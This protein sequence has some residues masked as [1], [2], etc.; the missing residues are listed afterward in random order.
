MNFDTRK[1]YPQGNGVRY[2]YH[3][4]KSKFSFSLDSFKGQ[5]KEKLKKRILGIGTAV[6]LIFAFWLTKNVVS[7]L[8]DVSSINNMVFSEATVIQDRNGK[9][10]YRLFEQNREYV[11]FSGISQNMINGIVAIEDQRYWDHNGLDPMGILRAAASNVFSPGKGLQ[12]AS[13]ISQQLVRNL[14]LSKGQTFMEKVTRKLKEMILTSRLDSVLEDQIQ[15]ENGELDSDMLRKQMKNKIL[16]LYLNYISFGNNAFGVESASKTY[17]DKSAKDLDVFESAILSSIPKGPSIY[18][19]YK[20]AAKLVGEFV[21]KGP[22]WEKVIMDDGLAT[23]IQA[24]FSQKLM[25]MSVAK[26]NSEFTTTLQSLGT[27]GITGTGGISLQVKYVPG[28][29]DAVI[30]RMYEDGYITENQAKQA[31]LE[32]ITYKFRKNKIDMLAPHFVQWIIETLEQQYDT[33]TLLKWGIVVKTSLDY[34]IQKLAEEALSSNIGVLQQNGANNSSMIYTDSKNWDVLAY[35]GSLNY[36]DESIKGQNDMVRKPRQ[37]GSSIK[38]LIYALGFEKLPLTIDTP[39]YDIPF[40]IGPDR[41][42]NADDLFSG[43]LPLRLALGQSRNIPSTKMIAALGSES[44]AKPYLISLGLSGIKQDIQYWYTLALGAGEVSMLELANAYTNLSTPT[45]AGINPILEIRSRDGS[46]LYQ[47]QVVKKPN[48]I[49]PGIWYLIWKVLSDTANRIV[50]WTNKFNVAGL[51]I[52]IKTGTSDVKTDKGNRPRDWWLASYTAS[53]VALFRAGNADATPLNKNAYGGTIQAEPMKRFYTALLKNNYITNDVIAPVDVANVTISKLSGKIANANT[54]AE[55]AVNTMYYSK[56]VPLGADEWLK[57]IEYDASCNGLSNEFTAPNNLK[58]WYVI[59]PTSFMPNK[60]D[61]NEITE[62]FRIGSSFTGESKWS[63]SSGKVVYNFN[64]IFPIMPTKVCDSTI[65][66]PDLSIQI[67]IISPKP[68]STVT[69]KF[70]LWYAVQ[71][72][73]P[74]NRIILLADSKQI[75]QFPGKG[76]TQI[77]DIRS[78]SGSLSAGVYAMSLVAVDND[79]FS[80]KKEFS[81]TVVATDTKAPEL[82]QDKTIVKKLD[83]GKYEVTLFFQDNLSFVSKW[84][85]NQNGTVVKNFEWDAVT[86]QVNDLSPL[87]IAITDAYENNAN[88]SITP[89]VIQ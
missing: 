82:I 80:N 50:G 63:Y 15:K 43:L 71:S 87:N 89:K 39:I 28:R 53:K 64:N 9:T 77:S 70:S 19:P 23:Q 83:T 48:I 68:D 73:R 61:I 29:K 67:D 41:P 40:Q 78:I 33:G 62:W 85:I 54:P 20:N 86:F 31:F 34:E 22:N 3:P 13:T 16:E 11:P 38:P 25:W 30:T 26:K 66:K 56:W 35:V 47:K 76:K 14:L 8:P 32:G 18:N 27:F 55:F 88:V 52:A 7:W 6:L 59:N 60:M 10:L 2:S 79:G 5:D 57:A 42:N 49:K 36:F 72:S 84:T 17:F 1:I 12:G 46:L 45:P 51:T 21:M 37:S 74:M 58:K 44:V 75:A 81:L 65:E 24:A 69:S 4:K